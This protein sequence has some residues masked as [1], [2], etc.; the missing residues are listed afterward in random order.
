[1][2]MIFERA[3]DTR[4]RRSWSENCC[5]LQKQHALLA[6]VDLAIPLPPR[7]LATTASGPHPVQM[8]YHGCRMRLQEIECPIMEC[9]Y[10][11]ICKDLY[12]QKYHLCT[13]SFHMPDLHHRC[14][15]GTILSL[16]LTCNK[17]STV[18]CLYLAAK[19]CLGWPYCCL[20]NC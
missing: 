16:Y 17:S 15:K 8:I 4:T 19:G 9:F 13:V 12:F 1:M 20:C 10:R 18:I 14:F 7:S 6:I 11:T 3:P 2:E 5:R